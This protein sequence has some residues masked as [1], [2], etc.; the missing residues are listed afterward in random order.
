MPEGCGLMN[1][2]LVEWASG[3]GWRR[4]REISCGNYEPEEISKNIQVRI[5]AEGCQ[6][7]FTGYADYVGDEDSI[8]G[9]TA[10]AGST[11]DMDM[12]MGVD[13]D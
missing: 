2:F 6:R 11:M 9:E 4:T 5:P 12:D 13:R 8:N 10:S 7:A 1:R 3:A